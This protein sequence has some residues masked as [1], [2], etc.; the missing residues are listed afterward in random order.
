METSCPNERTIDVGSSVS[1]EFMNAILRI[2]GVRRVERGCKCCE[3][4]VYKT[5]AADWTD[6]ET[7]INTILK[8]GS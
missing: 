3:I 5:P 4:V 1:G 6:V 7:Q 8:G 2:D